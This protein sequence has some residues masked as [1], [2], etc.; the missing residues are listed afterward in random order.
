MKNLLPFPLSIFFKNPLQ[1][2]SPEWSVE[3]L[4]GTLHHENSCRILKESVL[5]RF[6][7]NDYES[8]DFF[9]IGAASSQTTSVLLHS[10]CKSMKLILNI[11]YRMPNSSGNSSFFM[12]IFSSYWVINSSGLHL[13]GY[14]TNMKGSSEDSPQPV[15]FPVTDSLSPC[16]V[17]FSSQQGSNH[18]LTIQH[19]DM[20]P[21][22]P[23]PMDVVG[24]SGAVVLSKPHP[25]NCPTFTEI[26]VAV[27]K[28]AHTN[29][30]KI[31]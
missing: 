7:L 18:Y 10:S 28:S 2:A 13:S 27:S 6:K 25:D 30:T 22:S 15:Q 5:V 9:P 12:E 21:S 29:L 19:A 24:S 8:S 20:D 16:L 3:I 31:I 4:P 11:Q 14:P 17:G 1:T 26:V 23:V